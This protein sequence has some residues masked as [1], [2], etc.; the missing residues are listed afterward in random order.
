MHAASGLAA[1]MDEQGYEWTGQWQDVRSAAFCWC[2]S[3][4]EEDEGS[5]PESVTPDVSVTSGG[6]GRLPVSMVTIRAADG[7]NSFSVSLVSYR[8]KKASSLLLTWSHVLQNQN[9][10][11]P[12]LLSWYK[13]SS[14]SLCVLI[15]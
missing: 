11:I 6:G 2:E 14:L 15:G 12:V 3:D 13:S 10:S 4:E 7:T 8:H 5:L 1:V 9:P